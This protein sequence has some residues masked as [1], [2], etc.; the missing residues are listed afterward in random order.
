MASKTTRK[1]HAQEFANVVIGLLE[2]G[3]L[4]AFR[5]PWVGGV[6]HQNLVSKK[7]YRGTNTFI[8]AVAAHVNNFSSPYWMTIKQANELGGKV[9]KGSKGT[10]ITHFTQYEKKDEI[11]P[12]TGEAKI[13]FSRKFFTVFNAD[14]VEGIE[15]PEAAPV[16][17]ER[18][19][20]EKSADLVSYIMDYRENQ[21][22]ALNVGDSAYYSPVADSVTMPENFYSCDGYAAVL[23]HEFIHSTGHQKRLNRFEGNE[24]KF[25]NR[26]EEYAFEEIIT[27]L[28]AGTM[29]TMFG[30]ESRHDQHASYIDSWVKALRNDKEYIFKAASQSQKAIDFISSCVE[31]KESKAA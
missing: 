19:L 1:D 22:I 18:T 13:G 6:A 15:L 14:Q 17:A 23:A 31:E 24:V 29:C 10:A 30:I 26:R 25:S 9:K 7:P 16:F 20:D 3:D 4:S 2:K 8:L 28:A 11:D 21:G 27:E 12:K 5:M